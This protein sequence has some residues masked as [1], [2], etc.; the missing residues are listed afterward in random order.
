MGHLFGHEGFSPASTIS[1][2]NRGTLSSA[3][4]DTAVKQPVA[5]G[6]ELSIP[7]TTES[8]RN[9]SLEVTEWSGIS[10][11][12]SLSTDSVSETVETVRPLGATGVSRYGRQRVPNVRFRDYV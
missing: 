7:S 5:P 11:S 3:H 8:S 2:E 1:W 6:S 12:A 10:P 4:E 9:S